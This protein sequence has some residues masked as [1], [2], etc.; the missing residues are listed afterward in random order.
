[1]YRYLAP[2]LW[3]ML[4]SDGQFRTTYAS[5]S[6]AFAMTIL[7]M[8]SLQHPYAEF[9]T[10]EAAASQAAKGK[11]PP[12]SQHVLDVPSKVQDALWSLLDEMWAHD[13]ER[14][15]SLELA[16]AELQNILSLLATT[17]LE[18]PAS[19]VLTLKS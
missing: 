12:R 11:R 6:Y 15:P 1:M 16:E 10:A 4:L 14:R 18:V 13:P 8:V 19:L 2:E 7:E 5:D 9:R 17:S 3:S